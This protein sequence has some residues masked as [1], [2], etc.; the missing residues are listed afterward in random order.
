MAAPT[1]RPLVSIL[2][3]SYNQGAFLGRCIESVSQ[4]TYRPLEHIVCDGGSTDQTLDALRAAPET[5]TWRS[6]P[7]RGQSH[8]LNTALQQSNG[9]I[10]GWLNSDDAYFDPDTVSAVVEVFLR[11]PE[12]DVVYGHAALVNAS[13]EILHFMWVPRFNLTLLRATNFIIQP[14]AFVRR[15]ALGDTL[16][17]ETYDFSMDR[18]LW[19]RLASTHRFERADRVLAIDR[20]HPARKVYT[21]EDVGRADEARI[22]ATYGVPP[23]E[24]MKLRL[25]IYKA[26][27]RLL[28]LRLVPA[29]YGAH[30]ADIRSPGLARLVHRQIAMRRRAMPVGAADAVH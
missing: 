27:A 5:V 9:E 13:G 14:A 28:G 7:D 30:A 25:R 22:V 8:A 24:T 23:T 4:Q 19:L 10:I 20:H 3:P 2:T 11:R 12:V 17:D 18:E 29:A 15:R 16:A 6:G 26:C 21:R 1:S